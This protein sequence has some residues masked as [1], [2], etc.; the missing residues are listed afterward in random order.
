MLAAFALVPNAGGNACAEAEHRQFDFWLGDWQIEQA[1]T[2][3]NGE[4]LRLPA[5]TSVTLAAGGCALV[6]RWSGTVQ[7]FWE[8]MEKPEAMEGLSVRYFNPREGR[9]FI[10]W[11]DS[12]SA[13]F[14]EPFRGTF[15]DGL[16]TFTVTR[17]TPRGTSTSRITF[18]QPGRD[19][20]R[21]EL[22]VED[23]GGKWQPLWIMNMRR[24]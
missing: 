6:E 15:Q 14:G 19:R 16:G 13:S 9:W 23:G 21:W 11:L 4:T 8:G 22:A 17:A 20:V 10:H 24:R 1:I 2:G 5:T 7:F 3:A 12:R 18:A